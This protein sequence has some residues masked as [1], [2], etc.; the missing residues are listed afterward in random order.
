VE[1]DI[2]R[3]ERLAPEAYLGW[4]ARVR[5]AEE[6]PGDAALARMLGDAP[7]RRLLTRIA[8]VEHLRVHPHAALGP[9]LL[10]TFARAR[11][12]E[13]PEDPDLFE[14]ALRAVQQLPAAEQQRAI[15]EGLGPDLARL[16]FADLSRRWLGPALSGLPA[17]Q[18]DAVLGWPGR[19][20]E[21][22]QA[23][24]Q[25][26]AEDLDAAW[27]DHGPALLRAMSVE[28]GSIAH[29]AARRVDDVVLGAV[30]RDAPTG[31]R[32]ALIGVAMERAQD[33]PAV[34]AALRHLAE[35]HPDVAR[36]ATRALAVLPGAPLPPVAP[37]GIPPGR[38]PGLELR[39]PDTPPASVVTP[40][41]GP[42]GAMPGTL[43]PAAAGVL[44]FGLAGLLGA[45]GRRRGTRA[46]AGLGIAASVLLLAEAGG[47][48]A[49]VPLLADT[50][51]LFSFIP[52]GATVLSVPPT[53]EAGWRQTAGGS[54]RAALFEARPPDGRT[55]VAFLGASSVHGS[56]A[57][58]EET[59]AAV[60]VHAANQSLGA[61]ALE[62]LNLGVGG[63]TSAV[64][65]QAGE[66]AL[67]AGARVLVVY[68][69][70]NEV[71]QFIRLGRYAGMDPRLLRAR[72][73]LHRSALYSLLHRALPAPPPSAAMPD[74]A[75]A[76]DREEVQSLK[77]LAEAHHGWN[78]EALLRA[79]DRA[80]ARVILTRT[81][82]NHRFAHLEPHASPGPGDADDLAARRV[83]GDA[84]AASGDREG[85][86]AAWQGAIDVGAWPRE[87]T[88]G[89]DRTTVALAERYGCAVLDVGAL[90]AAHAP[91]GVT[92]SGMFWDDL[93]PTPEGHRI[94]GEALAP[95]LVQAS[96]DAP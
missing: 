17:A 34:H 39:P 66:S 2:A 83:H 47:R 74:P 58:A 65:R 8:A 89:I 42:H 16:A 29:L 4:T 67:A 49:G 41:D 50:E 53:G 55:R 57:L 37:P 60:A 52:P 28:G 25:A 3:H 5:S 86:R 73:V 38:I 91:D 19:H 78:L 82:V 93:H 22:W 11:F 26:V 88:S 64:V 36:E 68:Y 76:P 51:P 7:G 40:G 30:L 43:A 27:R 23:V 87:A 9:D 32:A 77:R 94:I 90:V 56:H 92:A 24:E 75:G 10:R 44:L 33:G 54:V 12:G 71:D 18:R 84:L 21:A 35:T 79:A 20:P 80:G 31:A 81:A 59:F 48:A 6:E 61:P 1:A 63:A 69:G 85:A 45:R 95:L 70:H 62:G 13:L 72:G 14:R 15:R 96:Q 46:L